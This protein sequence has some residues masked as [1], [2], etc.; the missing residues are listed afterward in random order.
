M[1]LIIV[2]VFVG[3]F[4]LVALPLIA[5]GSRAAQQAK[6]IQ[7]S[8]E[9]ALAIEG[10]NT[11]D[12]VLNFRKTD[13]VS[14]IPWLHR[15]LL[16]SELAPQIN[17]LIHQANLSWTPGGLLSGSALCFV[18]PSYLLSLRCSTVLLPLLVGL[19]FSAAPFGW[20]FFKRNKRMNKFQEELPTALDLMVSALRAGHSLAAAIG[21]V[22]RECA[23]PVGSEF[24]ICFD[25]Q[26]YGLEMKTALENLI[27]RVPIQA[28]RTVSTAIMIQK[29]SGGNLAEVLDK[30]AHVI[31]E[32]FRL[33]RQIAT[34]SAQGRL[35]GWILTFLP[36]VLGVALY[37]ANPEMMSILWKT[38]IGVKLLYAATGMIAVGG[39]IINRIIKGIDV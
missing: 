28:L 14:A 22:A 2:F 33:K 12:P 23:A 20:L 24:K 21:M 8:L 32:S 1:G 16:K 36:V 10:V 17:R 37:F 18:I 7:S 39:F 34:H 15:T 25:E 26:N 4:S 38:E 3:V 35:T 27:Q 6:Q 19:A 31:R 9:T 29:E 5:S 13:R 30:T 11:E